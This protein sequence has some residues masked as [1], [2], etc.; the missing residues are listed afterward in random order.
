M[1]SIFYISIIV[2]LCVFILGCIYQCCRFKELKKKVK[3][4]ILNRRKQS[5]V[6]LYGLTFETS[7]HSVKLND[8]KSEN[9]EC[10]VDSH[11]NQTIPEDSGNEGEI[12]EK[13]Q[14]LNRTSDLF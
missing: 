2:S 13:K 4:D 12:K 8:E 1:D 3:F 7:L 14:L 6:D 5:L 11:K 9:E 10:L